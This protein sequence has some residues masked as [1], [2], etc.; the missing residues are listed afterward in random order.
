[1]FLILEIDQV[2]QAVKSSLPSTY[3]WYSEDR[4]LLQEALREIKIPFLAED[5]SGSNIETVSARETPPAVIVEK[6][7]TVSFFGG[8]LLIVEELPYFQAGE[9]QEREGL[10]AYMRDPNPGTCL[11][12]CAENVNKGSKFYKAVQTAGVVMEFTVPRKSQEWLIWLKRQLET[13]GMS[14]TPGVAGQFLAQVG[15][16]AGI[17]AR[18]LDKLAVFCGEKKEIRA[19]DIQEIAVMNVE[20]SIFDLLDAI[21]AQSVAQAVGKLEE[22]LQSENALKVLATLTGHVRLL[23][24]AA[25]WRRQGGQGAELA[26]AL[27][28]NPYRAQKIWRQSA[29]LPYEQ[30]VKAM[31]LCLKTEAGVK[32]GLGEAAMLLELMVIKF[33]LPEG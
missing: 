23:L 31:T 1:M 26:S 7:N 6:A 12:F 33:C 25:A 17:L 4:Y 8:R 5:P 24:G 16:Q 19:E 28:I 32:S 11:L 22:V 10:Y 20:A 18:E 3:L 9:A 15:H 13:R 2:R 29:K 30:L 14:M 21:G 27:G